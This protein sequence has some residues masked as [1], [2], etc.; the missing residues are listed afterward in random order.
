MRLAGI[1][2]AVALITPFSSQ[3][4]CGE[5]DWDAQGRVPE[6]TPD[7]RA[8]ADVEVNVMQQICGSQGQSQAQKKV[9]SLIT[10]RVGALERAGGLSKDQTE[11]LRVAGA[12]DTQRFFRELDDLR[13]KCRGLNWND[14]K[15]Q[16]EIYP[17]MFELQS[18]FNGGLFADGSLFQKVLRSLAR[19]NPTAPYIK[20]EQ[21][22]QQSRFRAMIEVTVVR[23]ENGVSMTE[24]Q[25]QQFLKVLFDELKPPQNF[26]RQTEY[27]VFYQMTKIDEAKLRPIFDDAQWRVLGNWLRNAKA[28]EQHLK[29][30]GFVP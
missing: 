13:L 15:F 5:D 30:L 25:R 6:A 10:L 7:M 26:G 22:R 23:F 19:D 14:R 24:S 29:R 12:Q 16:E 18:R 27:V 17:K 2:V 3:P 20:E 4:T 9:E 21:D 1:A 8:A 11:K 28:M